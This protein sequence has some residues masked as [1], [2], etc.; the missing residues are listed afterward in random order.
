MDDT[1][2]AIVPGQG[3][4]TTRTQAGKP[5]TETGGPVRRNGMTWLQYAAK[6]AWRD[7]VRPDHAQAK[8]AAKLGRK[9]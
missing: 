4:S 8:F 7:K 6:R 5:W 2:G 9:A 1:F 3:M